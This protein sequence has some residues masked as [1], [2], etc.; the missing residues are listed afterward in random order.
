MKSRS[1][2]LRTAI[3]PGAPGPRP[4]TRTRRILTRYTRLKVSKKVKVRLGEARQILHRIR[5]ADTIAPKGL[6]CD[7]V[8]I[9]LRRQIG[10]LFL[11]QH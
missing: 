8:C 10:F 1:N 6:G 11:R 9:D 2:D 3:V 5:N 7:V 4:L